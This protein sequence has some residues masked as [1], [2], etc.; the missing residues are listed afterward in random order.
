MSDILDSSTTAPDAPRAP[1]GKAGGKAKSRAKGRPAHGRDGGRAF[2]VPRLR[3]LPVVIFTAVLMLSVRLGG[4]WQDV[5]L[6][7]ASVEI[8]QS[9]AQAQSGDGGAQPAPAVT[10]MQPPLGEGAAPQVAEAAPAEQLA[11]SGGDEAGGV[12]EGAAMGPASSGTDPLKDPVNFTQS[13]ID[14]LQKLAERRELIESRAQELEQREALL[15]AA[16]TRID[17]KIEEL[18]TLQTTIE[19]LLKKH[20]EQEEQKIAQLVK[21]YA[22]MKP[23]D[24]ARIFNDLDMPI[25]LTVLENMKEASSAPILAAMD[26]GKARAVTEELSQRRRI[27]VP[28]ATEGG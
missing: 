15:K 1:K 20:D 19:G 2:K 9:S 10:R 25:L 17:R 12:P 28:G 23:K 27:P 22:T 14:L 21:I 7:L 13:E 11:A 18:Q 26:A 8:G 4:L 16:E 24:A 5:T 3:L 6:R